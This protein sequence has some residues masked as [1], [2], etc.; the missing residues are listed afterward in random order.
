MTA[1]VL[2]RIFIKDRD[3]VNDK[4]VRAAWGT[5][6]SAVGIILNVLLFIGKFTVG[7]LFGMISVS[8][9]AV[10]NLSDA[11][12]QLIS[13]VSFRLSSKPADRKHPF[14]HARIEY[15][16]SM[17]VS[18]I[19]III[20]FS[21]LSESLGK[22]ASPE[23]VTFSWVTVAV[24]GVSVLCKVYLALL[25]RTVGKKIDS[26]VMR[27][28]TADSLSD[29]GATGAVLLAYIISAASGFNLDAYFGVIVSLLIM[30]AG[31]KI[32]NEMKNTL[33]GEAPDTETV[34]G[35]VEIVEAH[36]EEG[37]L[38][39]HDLAVHNYGPGRTIASLHVEVDGSSDI[40]VTHDMIDNI[41]A[42]LREKL[43][44]EATIHLDPIVVGEE[45]YTLR[46]AVAE[47]LCELDR[48]ITIHD[49]RF[50]RGTTH[51]NLI[52]DLVMPYE[53]PT[54]EDEMID[55]VKSKV[56]ELDPTYNAVVKIDRG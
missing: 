46:T 33:L 53:N 19:I 29:A 12:S 37:A 27:A 50:V 52:F 21:L 36:R 55:A 23:E 39:I 45:A 8:A 25:N 14:G 41:E 28:T 13:L 9:D 2:G 17:I 47:K 22:L 43:G 4:H 3:N 51:T 10:N 32:L 15:V 38:G 26:A 30:W 18:M 16:A 31:V 7:S 1:N 34:E 56:R 20:G 5:L 35:I 54:P 49:F 40:F 44:I 6:V 48:A 24:L 42:E 11:G